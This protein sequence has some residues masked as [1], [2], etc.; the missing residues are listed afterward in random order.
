[1]FR[2]YSF[3][4]IALWTAGA[5]AGNE[6]YYR[7][8]ARYT[9]VTLPTPKVPAGIQALA[10]RLES[11]EGTYNRFRES[12]KTRKWVIG[13]ERVDLTEFVRLSVFVNWMISGRAEIKTQLQKAYEQS[14]NRGYPWAKSIAESYHNIDSL[15]AVLIALRADIRQVLLRAVYSESD[16]KRLLRAID[17][18]QAFY[19]V[20]ELTCRVV[21]ATPLIVGITKS[22]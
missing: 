6:A 5:L 10:R 11:I 14:A 17:E 3:K 22:R 2:P 16:R 20:D 9:G 7:T 18:H 1:M 19:Y 12:L 21:G 15:V 4:S 13:N 8:K